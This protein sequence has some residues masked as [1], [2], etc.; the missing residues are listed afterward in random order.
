MKYV[1]ASVCLLAL[2][3]VAQGAATWD[4]RMAL[5]EAVKLEVT[6]DAQG[7]MSEIEY[8]VDPS[9]MPQHIKDAMTKAFPGKTVNITAGEKEHVDGVLHYELSAEIDGME[10]EA[11]FT[12]SGQP[13]VWEIQ[14]KQGVVPPK[15]VQAIQG[16]Y[17]G[18]DL[19]KVVWEKIVYGGD[20]NGDP[21]EYHVKVPFQGKNYKVVLA[22]TGYVVDTFRE[23]PA[24]IEVPVR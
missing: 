14:V 9:T 20:P 12:E 19:T 5:D 7:Q 21:S 16:R 23:I 18:A 8:H 15:V 2:V 24:E 22:P 11:M 17:P 6:L 3:V 1:F 4:A 10:Y 13:H